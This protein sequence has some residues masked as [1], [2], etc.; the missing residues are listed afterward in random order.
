MVNKYTFYGQ[1]KNKMCLYSSPDVLCSIINLVEFPINKFKIKKEDN[2]FFI[3]HY[4]KS[5]GGIM[6]KYNLKKN[7]L[8]FSFDSNNQ[9]LKYNNIVIIFTK[10]GWK[11]LTRLFNL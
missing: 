9:F 3:Y 8:E 1:F 10:K 6:G 5:F 11:K 4:Y 7:K 2:C